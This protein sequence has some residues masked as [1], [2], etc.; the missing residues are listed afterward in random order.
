M[1]N[2]PLSSQKKLAKLNKVDFEMEFLTWNQSKKR[3]AD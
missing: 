2:K 3:R 1:F